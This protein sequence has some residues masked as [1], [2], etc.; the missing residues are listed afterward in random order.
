MGSITIK[1]ASR[2]QLRVPRTGEK[3]REMGVP[4]YDNHIQG[5]TH[6]KGQCL[7]LWPS[8]QEHTAQRERGRERARERERGK[9]EEGRVFP[10]MVINIQ[11]HTELKETCLQLWR[12]PRST[13]HKERTRKKE[14]EKDKK[15]GRE[16]GVPSYDSASKDTPK[17]KSATSYDDASRYALEKE[18]IAAKLHEN[19]QWFV[20]NLLLGP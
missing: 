13:L 19:T 4:S 3:T 12:R 5:H 18:T 6:C 11:G 2:P 10:A 20:K 9:E 15:K 14:R 16:Q 17:G 1:A 7:Q 8:T